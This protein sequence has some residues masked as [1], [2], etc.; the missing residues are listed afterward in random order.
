[1]VRV[2]KTASF[3]ANALWMRRDRNGEATPHLSTKDDDQQRPCNV[4]VIA[5][6][7]GLVDKPED[8]VEFLRYLRS[9]CVNNCGLGR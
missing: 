1:M 9:W 2:G 5:S 8:G 7:G 6:N 4:F 3:Q